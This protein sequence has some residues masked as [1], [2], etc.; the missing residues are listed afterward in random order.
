MT[1]TLEEMEEEAVAKVE[2]TTRGATSS[3]PGHLR[4]S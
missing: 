1:L 3:G 4:T 2:K